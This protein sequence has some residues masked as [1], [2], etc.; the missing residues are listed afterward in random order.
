MPPPDFRC[1]GTWMLSAGGIPIPT[2]PH[3]AARSA[4]IHRH[5]Y[6]VLTPEEHNDPLW[7]PD[8]EDQWTTFFTER[9][10]QELAH[11]E[12]NGPPPANRNVAAQKL[13]WGVPGRILAFVLDNIAMGNYPWLTMPRRMDAPVSSSS[14]SSLSTPRTPRA[15]GIVIG[16]PPS[17]P[18]RLLCP[19]KESGLSS[20]SIA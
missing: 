14:R 6:E 5:Y 15:G 20:M 8:N 16:S 1:L 9:R 11:Y 7:D 19:K 3:G 18:T 10:N 17:A 4:T 12:G 13:W 2:V